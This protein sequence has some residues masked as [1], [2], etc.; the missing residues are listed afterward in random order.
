[1][2][3]VPA[4]T[5]NIARP[6]AS[7]V[8]DELENR[9]P[10]PHPPYRPPTGA[11]PSGA[12]PSPA[13]AP[14][15]G[16][17]TGSWLPPT[18]PPRPAVGVGDSPGPA[19]S[20][21]AHESSPPSAGKRRSSA[22]IAAMAFLVGGAVGAGGFGLGMRYAEEPVDSAGSVVNT[23][24]PAIGA[25]TAVATADT[26]PGAESTAPRAATPSGV[27][28]AADV[29]R[30]LG[31]SVV[32]VET[33]LGQGS[34]VVYDD[35]LLLTNHHVI[36]GAD[37]V[38]IRTADGLVIP[39]EV[40]GS[41][42]RN[43][44]AVLSAPDGDLPVAT[45][46]SSADLEPGQLTVAIGSPF[47]LQQTVTA[48]IVSS[49]NRPVPNAD[50]SFSAMIQ[51]DAPINPGN[52][53][54][55]LANRNGELVGINASIRTDGT[56]NSNVGI[57]F[58]VP[59]DTAIEVANRI[60]DGESLDPGVLGVSGQNQDGAAG[61]PVL[62]VF[63]GSGA[64]AAGLQVGDRVLTIDDV[65]VTNIRELT[66]LVQSRFSGDSVELEVQRGDTTLTLTAVL[67]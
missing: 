22:L 29:A 17:P 9:D 64:E 62:G 53:G 48:G 23:S 35:G 40:L 61:V 26:S 47:Q 32:Q 54:G 44:I 14:L 39:V 28:P 10:A 38:R 59:I 33:N 6:P 19:G 41:D 66:G 60:V 27:E 51:T 1:M 43:D 52:S 45:I 67:S 7:G 50:G 2:S 25:D 11:V 57:G 5:P 21:L 18:A 13:V 37:Q 8:A 31:P 3:P 58:A 34:G 16:R 49:T 20:P 4:S 55:A 46:G 15:A 65:P 63:E 24:A 12:A 42:P 56:G 36:T 30:I